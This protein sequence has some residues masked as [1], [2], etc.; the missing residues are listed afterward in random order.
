MKFHTQ[1]V[2]ITINLKV[3]I[4]FTLSE[5]STTNIVTWY[6]HFYESAMVRYTMFLGRHILTE[7]ELNRKLSYHVIEEDDGP[8]KGYTV[9]I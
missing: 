9:P 7:L 4:E 2:K 3:K 1:E 6:C 8:F 5:L